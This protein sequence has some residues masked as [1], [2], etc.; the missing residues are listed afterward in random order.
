MCIRDRVDCYV[1]PW[2]QYL[3][4]VCRGLFISGQP[5]HVHRFVYA[6]LSR[7]ESFAASPIV[8]NASASMLP[9]WHV[10]PDIDLRDECFGG[11]AVGQCHWC[12]WHHIHFSNQSHLHFSPLKIRNRFVIPCRPA[13]P[14]FLLAAPVVSAYA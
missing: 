8:P 9:Q 2:I 10:E 6:T 11:L 14:F 13:V 1:R 3:N 12:H 5:K 7:T 4:C